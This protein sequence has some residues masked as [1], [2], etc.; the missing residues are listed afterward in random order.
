MTAGDN[1]D[2]WTDEELKKIR[3]ATLLFIC[4][5]MREKST[6]AFTPY[7][8]S[9]NGGIRGYLGNE[10]LS[11][12]FVLDNEG[13]YKRQMQ[14]VVQGIVNE[15]LLKPAAGSAVFEA[16]DELARLCEKGIA[17]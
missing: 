3:E 13:S 14:R 17:K 11:R 5:E 6:M 7:G 10:E 16:T 9:V 15:G 4:R 2:G 1:N 12:K 8:Q